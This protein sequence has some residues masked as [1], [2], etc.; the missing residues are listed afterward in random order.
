MGSISC[1]L[2]LILYQKPGYTSSVFLFL[3][4]E[5]NMRYKI[6][7]TILKMYFRKGRYKMLTYFSVNLNINGIGPCLLFLLLAYILLT[8]TIHLKFQRRSIMKSICKCKNCGN[9]QYVA[10]VEVGIDGIISKAPFGPFTCTTCGELYEAL[11]IRYY[12]EILIPKEEYEDL[13]YKL[14][15]ILLLLKMAQRWKYPS[16]GSHTIRRPRTCHMRRHI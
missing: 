14:C 15:V 11:P 16:K 6:I 7:H 1:S 8:S 12:Q 3:H 5:R 10:Y 2:G 13:A 4:K 9:T